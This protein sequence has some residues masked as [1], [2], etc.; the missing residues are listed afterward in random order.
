QRPERDAGV[1][2]AHQVD[3]EEHVDAI[4]RVDGRE[5]PCLRQLVEGDDDADRRQ[6]ER[7]AVYPLHGQ[8]WISRTTMPARKI[9]TIVA[10]IGL[11]S[12]A[13]G[14][15]RTSG[16]KRLNRFRYGSV[17]LVTKSRKALSQ[18]LYGIRGSQLS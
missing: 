7:P 3:A 4:P 17:T 16:M 1:A 11:R 14:P 8:P 6:R 13:P 5:R 18:R 15:T 9:R 12:I 10:I 2:D